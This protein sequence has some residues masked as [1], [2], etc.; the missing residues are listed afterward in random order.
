[1]EKEG[2]NISRGR[3]PNQG[4]QEVSHHILESFTKVTEARALEP[5]LLFSNFTHTRA[6]GGIKVKSYTE[7]SQGESGKELNDPYAAVKG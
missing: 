5:K 2:P 1:M 6:S 4:T 3:E 7:F